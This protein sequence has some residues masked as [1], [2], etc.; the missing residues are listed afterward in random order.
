MS[1]VFIEPIEIEMESDGF[2][3]PEEQYRGTTVSKEG[4]YHV[5]VMGVEDKPGRD[6]DGENRGHLRTIKVDLQIL[7]GCGLDE[8]PLP[9]Q[10]G[11]NIYKEFYVETWKNKDDKSEGRQLIDKKAAKGLKTPFWAFGLMSDEE[12]KSEKV[13][14]PFHLLHGRQAVVK[15][16]RESSW[17]DKD[18]K[19]RQGR[20][21]VRWNS[22]FYPVSHEKVA[23]IPKD[24]DYL[25]IGGL[26]GASQKVTDDMLSDL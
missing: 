6:P 16:T 11:L 24:A 17:T 4:W 9:D 25:A 5:A 15:V 19:E 2:D 23:A 18:G 22:D 26:D 14:F 3:S 7:A 1:E 8:K 12:L 20:L 10:K 13:R 21:T